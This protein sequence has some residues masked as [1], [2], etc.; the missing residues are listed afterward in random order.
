MRPIKTYRMYV[1]GAR[2][3]RLTRS[4]PEE[5]KPEPVNEASRAAMPESLTLA[6]VAAL[7]LD[8]CKYDTSLRPKAFHKMMYFVE[9]ELNKE[10]V[11]VDFPTF[12]YMY[13]AVMATSDSGVDVAVADDG[14]QMVCE[15]NVKGIDASEKVVRRG[16]RA[17]ARVL[18]RYY[19][20]GIEGLT[21]EM[22]DEAPYDVQRHYRRLDKQLNTATDDQQMT[23]GGGRNEG[24]TRETL[25]DFVESFPLA[26]FPTYED[27]L[28]IWY[29]LM[30]AELDSEDYNPSRAQ[31]LA[32]L[33]W[34]L[35]SLEL[36]CRQNS[37]LSRE[38][39]ARELS[40]ESVTEAK[41]EIRETLRRYERE[42][43]R[44]NAR[45]SDEAI[46]AAEAFV[47]PH[48]EF[49]VVI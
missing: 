38:E 26:E 10:H 3:Q 17:V 34:R 9:R 32:E 36:A 49:E 43:A 28:H 12:W 46:K 7:L 21:D 13:G 18:D 35:F 19:D 1:P 39:V 22:Y 24:L 27:D 31:E 30:S 4:F 48:L 5:L 15:V 8:E 20:L 11:H 47:V 40:I 37:E 16:R 33:F 14:Q 41:E 25:Y 23:L 44:R 2:Q 29:R 42:K 45:D 6:E